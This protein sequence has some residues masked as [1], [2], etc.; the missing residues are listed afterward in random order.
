MDDWKNFHLEQSKWVD[1][2][3]VSHSWY[4][5]ASLD[6][7]YWNLVRERNGEQVLTQE[8]SEYIIQ[9]LKDYSR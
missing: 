8:D 7:E 6:G 1:Q 9:T 5:Y 2:M 3:D 4:H